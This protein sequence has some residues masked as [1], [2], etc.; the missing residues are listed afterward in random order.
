MV[1]LIT[2][3][4]WTNSNDQVSDNFCVQELLWLTQWGRLA[5]PEQDNLTDIIKNN[6]LTLTTKIEVIRAFFEKPIH[7]NSTYRPNAYS[8]LVGGFAGDVHTMGMAMDFTIESI[9]C[10]EA[11][12]LMLPMLEQWNVRLEDNGIGL[13][14]FMLIFTI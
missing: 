2:D 8:R 11:K 4:D 5:N 7:V 3:I 13:D 6:L 12:Y 9:T 1:K 14:G 10:D